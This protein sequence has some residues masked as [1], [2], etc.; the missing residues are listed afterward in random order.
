[1]TA[2]EGFS[3]FSDKFRTT[4]PG[5][6]IDSLG[7]VAPDTE[8]ALNYKE[9]IKVLKS[10]DADLFYQSKWMFEARLLDGADLE[11]NSVAFTSYARSG[12]S[13]MRKILEQ[14][15]GVATG[16]TMPLFTSTSL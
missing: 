8:R 6:R 5:Y 1:M 2:R 4:Y 9:L 7:C 3:K 14:I 16:G 13:M 11:N 10:K 12:N 15:S